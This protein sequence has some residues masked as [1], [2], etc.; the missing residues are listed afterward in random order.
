MTH[1]MSLTLCN[2]FI[3]ITNLNM[4][5]ELRYYFFKDLFTF[6]LRIILQDKYSYKLFIITQEFCGTL[7]LPF[8]NDMSHLILFIPHHMI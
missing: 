5:L 1:K 6:N 7:F 2:K 3:D 8:N 4:W